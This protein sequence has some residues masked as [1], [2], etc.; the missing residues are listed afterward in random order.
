MFTLP[1]LFVMLGC[2]IKSNLF[3]KY[4]DFS[5]GI[6]IYAFPIQ[7]LVIMNI[8]DISPMKLTTYSFGI[9]LAL[10]VFSWFYVE[11]PI[12]KLK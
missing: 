8:P 1:Y 9:T 3:S 4:G 11:R 5:Y 2:Y 12:L 7:Q 6:Y 10:S